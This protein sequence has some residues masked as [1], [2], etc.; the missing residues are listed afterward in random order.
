MRDKRQKQRRHIHDFSTLPNELSG[1]KHN[2]KHCP[3]LLSLFFFVL[4]CQHVNT[5][6]ANT[7]QNLPENKQTNKHKLVMNVGV[8]SSRCTKGTEGEKSSGFSPLSAERQVYFYP[9]RKPPTL[10]L[11]G[12]GS[13]QAECKP[14]SNRSI[15]CRQRASLFL[16]L[17]HSLICSLYDHF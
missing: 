10:Y 6:L 2:A 9:R 17:E 12:V 1:V 11:P 4:L 8:F 7:K 5:F 14:T 13:Q 15:R 3:E 16:V